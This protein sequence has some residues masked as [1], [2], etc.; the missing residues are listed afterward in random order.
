MDILSS[1]GCD[2]RARFNTPIQMT[3]ARL[4]GQDVASRSCALSLRGDASVT[5]L[6]VGCLTAPLPPKADLDGEEEAS[7]SGAQAICA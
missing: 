4:T 2:L 1:A 3:P 5:D 7:V 6:V